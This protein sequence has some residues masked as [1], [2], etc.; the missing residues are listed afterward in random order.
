MGFRLG[1][2]ISCLFSCLAFS[3]SAAP[4]FVFGAD[5]ICDYLRTLEKTRGLRPDAEAPKAD[6]CEA[7]QKERL[8]PYLSRCLKNPKVPEGKTV[9]V[10]GVSLESCGPHGKNRR[11]RVLYSITKRGGI[12]E[13]YVPIKY[14]YIGGADRKQ[15]VLEATA[16][17]YRCAQS[18]FHRHGFKLIVDLVENH[19]RNG[20]DTVQLFD[21]RA[22][23]DVENWA[24]LQTNGRCMPSYEACN[25][26][27]HELSHRLGL[28]DSEP[29]P[30]CRSRKIGPVDDVM[31][32]VG[33]PTEELRFYPV[34][35]RKIAKALCEAH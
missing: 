35:I 10:D 2:R 15:A 31:R 7:C 13:L 28:D 17:A 20:G 4:S 25:T 5:R 19:A 6:P 9:H 8:D 29:D 23:T 18:F 34:E 33:R 21:D 26:F 30:S 22:S 14:I 12:L 24:V 3:A 27:I 16:D 11:S 1:S 32:T